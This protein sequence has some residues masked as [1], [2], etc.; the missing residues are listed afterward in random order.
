MDKFESKLNT[1]FTYSF[2]KYS[3][4]REMWYYHIAM[5][6]VIGISGVACMV[7]RLVPAW[8]WTHVWWGRIYVIAMLWCTATSLL[9]HNDG[10]PVA[11]LVAFFWVLM[12]LSLGWIAIN[13]HQI[14]LKT[15]VEKSLDK[16]IKADGI[17]GN[18]SLS[19]L[20][21]AETKHIVNSRTFTQRFFSFKSLHGI[22]MVSSWGSIVGR[23]FASNQSGDFTCHT[24]P[25]YKQVEFPQYGGDNPSNLTFVPTHDPRFDRLPWSDGPY[26]WAIR[27]IISTIFICIIVGAISSF[28]SSRYKPKAET[29][30]SKRMS[31]MG[32]D[33]VGS[34]MNN[35]M[36]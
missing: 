10:L 27:N 19:E 1:D 20:L 2:D 32:Q 4:V 16:K 34:G 18:T 22:M 36:I 3:C 14:Q 21:Q 31:Q 24:Y 23:L 6:Y 11:V 17:M 5:A 26:E 30:G 9:I 33:V 12:G 13:F 28:I 35:S 8:K 7:T 29:S 15:L 25:T